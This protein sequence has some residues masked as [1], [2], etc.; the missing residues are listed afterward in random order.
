MSLLPPNDSIVSKMRE[1]D[2]ML[3]ERITSLGCEVGEADPSPSGSVAPT[4]SAQAAL[5]ITRRTSV[6]ATE[7]GDLTGHHTIYHQD[8]SITPEEIDRFGQRPPPLQMVAVQPSI[9]TPG[10]RG[11]RRR[12]RFRSST[13]NKMDPTP[14]NTPFL[15]KP[16]R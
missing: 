7:N 6:S 15:G 5:T 8:M 13:L 2:I 12:G 9:S 14:V 3:H 11:N 16:M 4:G 10:I 1:I